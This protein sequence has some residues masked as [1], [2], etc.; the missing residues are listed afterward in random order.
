MKIKL[1]LLKLLC[2]FLWYIC[3]N[4]SHLKMHYNRK[5]QLCFGQEMLDIVFTGP[6]SKSNKRKT[7]SHFAPFNQSSCRF[8][9]VFFFIYAFMI[10]FSAF[11]VM[12]YV[13]IDSLCRENHNCVLDMGHQSNC[14]HR[15]WYS[16]KWKT[17]YYHLAP[18]TQSSCRFFFTVFYFLYHFCS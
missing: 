6:V 17:F 10:I 2:V 4:V 15:T 11:V 3:I 13:Y 14:L 5:T 18:F 8:N 7:L 12:H 9:V 16:H 1:S